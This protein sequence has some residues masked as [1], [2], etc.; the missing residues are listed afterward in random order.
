LSA[1]LVS[2]GFS[3]VL[4][5]DVSPSMLAAARELVIDPRVE[6]VQNDRPDLGAVP[7]GSIDL[8]YSCRVLQHLPPSVAHGY[9][10]EFLRV[11]APGA[12]VVFQLPSG[13]APGPVG[14]ALRLAPRWLVDRARKGMQMHGT[15]PAEVTRL[16]A[17]AGGTTI[18]IEDDTSAGPRWR[19]HLYVTR[20]RA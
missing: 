12:P 14:M 16:V 3:R 19:S 2:A 13:P 17:E 7:T 1:A 15:A 18:S 9:I 10:R 5:V 8:V 6:F 11:A 20:A 4:G